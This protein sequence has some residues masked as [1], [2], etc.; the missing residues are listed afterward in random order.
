M[1]FKWFLVESK[2]F[3]GYGTYTP[4]WLF[5]LRFPKAYIKFEYNMMR[6]KK[7]V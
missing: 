3:M 7:G 4:K 1:N 6:S 2:K 5:W